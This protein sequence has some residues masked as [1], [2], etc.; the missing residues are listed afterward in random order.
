LRNDNENENDN[1]EQRRGRRDRRKAFA[2][3]LCVLCV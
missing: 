2:K 1:D 3:H